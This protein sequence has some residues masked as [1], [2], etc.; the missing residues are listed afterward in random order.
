MFVIIPIID[1]NYFKN[2]NLDKYTILALRFEL[3]HCPLVLP[4]LE[5]MKRYS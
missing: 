5:N 1:W 2:G 4:Q 3:Q